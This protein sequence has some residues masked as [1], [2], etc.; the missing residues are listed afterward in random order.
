[1]KKTD[2]YTGTSSTPVLVLSVF[3]RVFRLTFGLVG[4]HDTPKISVKHENSD[5]RFTMD[6]TKKTWDLTEI[7]V[8]WKISLQKPNKK[9]EISVNRQHSSSIL[10]R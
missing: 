8:C 7:S 9:P 3:V 10:K 5:L 1:M 2:A 4:K 6:R